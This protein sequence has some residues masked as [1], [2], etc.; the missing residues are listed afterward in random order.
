[1]I[2]RYLYIVSLSYLI[3]RTSASSANSGALALDVTGTASGFYP[4]Q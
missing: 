4:F 1:M 2:S 3:V